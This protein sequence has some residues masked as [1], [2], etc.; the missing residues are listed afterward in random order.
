M[1]SAQTHVILITGFLGSGKTTL[2]NRITR[3][4][5]P[6]G[7]LMILM[8]EFGEIGIDGTLIEGEDLDIVEISRGSV[9]CVCVKTDFIKA[10]MQIASR[11]RPDLLIIEATGVADPSDLKRDLMLSIFKSQF[12]LNHQCCLIDALNF[13]DAYDT[14]TT[15]EKQLESSTLFI[16]NKT[17]LAGPEQIAR[18]REIVSRHH[19]DPIFHETTFSDIP[20]DA[21][22]P[23]VAAPSPAL[24]DD[25][26]Q[27]APEIIQAVIDEQCRAASATI[28][29][30]DTFKSAV[31]TLQ[32]SASE[33][34]TD[35]IA[36]LPPDLVRA[37]GF[38]SLDRHMH[39][40]SWVM[41]THELRPIDR[42]D[43][44]AT[45]QNRIVFI[46]RP[47]TLKRLATLAAAHP[48]LTAGQMFDPMAAVN[49]NTRSG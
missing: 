7:K 33:T 20:L 32:P 45:L 14:F 11:I 46:A 43:I 19:P 2:L 49:G 36:H 31:Y 37:K 30:A 3:A 15:I 34:I 48:V 26:P 29:P 22:L 47:D 1:N 4:F 9:F 38:I 40:F 16:I 10:L 5:P 13:E 21:L 23:Q 8:N 44:P 12:K 39:L 6:T 24:P 27:P 28:L 25:H 18:I 35:L 17:D 41:G 42:A